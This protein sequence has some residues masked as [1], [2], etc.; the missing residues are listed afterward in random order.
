MNLAML[1]TNRSPGT[2]FAPFQSMKSLPVPVAQARQN[3]ADVLQTAKK[4]G[5]VRLTRH[6]KPVGW[7]I[8]EQERNQLAG[9][10][11]GAAKRR[12]GPR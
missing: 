4:G 1:L 6:G 11:E 12:R 9:G 2:G 3:M 5:R 10:A 7:I 8:G